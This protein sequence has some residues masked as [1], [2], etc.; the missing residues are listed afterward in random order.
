MGKES[1][2]IKQRGGIVKGE[3]RRLRNTLPTIYQYHQ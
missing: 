2:A 1:G 3:R